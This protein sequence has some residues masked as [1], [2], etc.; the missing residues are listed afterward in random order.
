MSLQSQKGM[1]FNRSKRKI[2]DKLILETQKK[3]NDPTKCKTHRPYIPTF[4]KVRNR[5]EKSIISQNENKNNNINNEINE[6][7]FI[8]EN[9]LARTKNLFERLKK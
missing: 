5:I 6:Y 1:L 8:F 7:K 4:N 3:E 2:N 9:L